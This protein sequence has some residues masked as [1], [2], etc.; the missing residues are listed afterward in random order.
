VSHIA[1]AL[2]RS[3]GKNLPSGTSAPM[4]GTGVLP[5]LRIGPQ[6]TPVLLSGSLS[7]FPLSGSAASSSSTVPAAPK[8]PVSTIVAPPTPP[9]RGVFFGAV[10]VIVVI[11]GVCAYF[12]LKTDNAFSQFARNK[13]GASPAAGSSAA[14]TANAPIT[15]VPAKATLSAEPERKPPSEALAEKVRILPITGAAG[16]ASQRLSVNGKIYEPGETVSEGL[17]LQSI[18]TEEIVFRDAEGNL[19]TRRL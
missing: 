16:G 10:S 18:E 1:T 4:E 17:I 2:A 15:A 5:A 9:K 13:A 14:G 12:L 11:A 7:P 19:Y 3:K 8:A 6:T